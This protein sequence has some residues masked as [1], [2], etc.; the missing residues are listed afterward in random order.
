M[1]RPRRRGRKSTHAESIPWDLAVE[2][3][4]DEGRLIAGVPDR[5]WRW[6]RSEDA[7]PAYRVL[8]FLLARFVREHRRRCAG[9]DGGARHEC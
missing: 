9:G 2:I 3:A 4:G 5:T 1:T 7:V 6:W 8:R